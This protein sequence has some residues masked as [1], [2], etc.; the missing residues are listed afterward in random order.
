MK[1]WGNGD[2]ESQ[3]A[4]DAEMEEVVPGN[5]ADQDI[6]WDCGISAPDLWVFY[7]RSVE[8]LLSPPGAGVGEQ[9]WASVYCRC[10]EHTG[11]QL[12][13]RDAAWHVGSHLFIP[14]ESVPGSR[15]ALQ[16][17]HNGSIGD[18]VES[19]AEGPGC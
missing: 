11:V 17:E 10:G 4:Q 2:S 1:W 8:M 15:G 13:M 12:E 6:S 19:C 3:K 9:E 5:Q 7:F 14:P 18:T 16:G